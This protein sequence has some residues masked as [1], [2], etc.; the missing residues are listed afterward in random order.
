MVGRCLC[1]KT[2]CLILRIINR[3]TIKRVW[4]NGCILAF[5]VNED[6]FNS[7]YPL[8][9][10]SCSLAQ[11]VEHSTDNRVVA[12]SSPART[13]KDLMRL[14]LNWMSS[15]LLHHRLQVRILSG[16][17]NSKKD[18][19]KLL[20][21]CTIWSIIC[22]INNIAN[23]DMLRLSQWRQTQGRT[24]PQSLWSEPC[25]NVVSS[26]NPPKWVSN[27]LLA[28]VGIFCICAGEDVKDEI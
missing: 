9:L 19:R 8:Q 7:H 11:L 23:R 26:R 10:F 22:V 4:Y 12:G 13:T 25:C 6:E 21:R 18:E 17:P 15:G 5:H 1:A 28:T 16:V 3:S 2:L 27:I 20:T 24:Y 14:K